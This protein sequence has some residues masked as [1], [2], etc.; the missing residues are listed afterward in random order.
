LIYLAIVRK[1]RAASAATHRI[2]HASGQTCRLQATWIIR[3]TPRQGGLLYYLYQGVKTRH[4][5]ILMIF[6]AS[7]A[8]T[9][10]GPLDRAAEQPGHLAPA[11]SSGIAMAL[12]LAKSARLFAMKP[13]PSP[14]SATRCGG[15]TPSSFTSAC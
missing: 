8:M 2:R 9:D 7:G 13:L 6:L 1:F 14:S 3:R 15:P 4:L 12:I 5:S 11:R 10:F